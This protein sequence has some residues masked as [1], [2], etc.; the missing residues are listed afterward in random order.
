MATVKLLLMREGAEP[1]SAEFQYNARD[2][3]KHIAGNTVSVSVGEPTAN[4]IVTLPLDILTLLMGR[5]MA[6]AGSQPGIIK[7]PSIVL[8]N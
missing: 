2:L 5:V 6:K 3:P 7:P 1:V 4:A 8:P